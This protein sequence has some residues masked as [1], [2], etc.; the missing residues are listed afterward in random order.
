MTDTKPFTMRLATALLAALL[1]AG[2]VTDGNRKQVAGTL[3]GAGLGG[4][5]GSKVGGG[6]GQLAAVAIGALG[7][8]LIGGSI[9]ESLDRADQLYAERA[10]NRAHDA[11]LGETVTWSNSDSGNS[12]AVTPTREG[13]QAAT[14]AYCREYQT[15]ITVDGSQQSAYG[16]A[17][18]QPDGSWRMI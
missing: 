18:Q 4:W 11:R 6:K 7:G 15:T 10:Q 13:T 9:G 3:L 12:G 14:G 5:A 17:C 2:C 1:V 16:T 8:A